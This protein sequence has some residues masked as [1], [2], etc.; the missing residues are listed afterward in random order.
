MSVIAFFFYPFITP[1]Y[2]HTLGAVSHSNIKLLLASVR[3]LQLTRPLLPFR[4]I[5]DCPV[6]IFC[7]VRGVRDALEKLKVSALTSKISSTISPK[8]LTCC[9]AKEVPFPKSN[10]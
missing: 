2:V 9:P 10:V 6:D 8:L 1:F 5:A 4:A 7:I 3:I